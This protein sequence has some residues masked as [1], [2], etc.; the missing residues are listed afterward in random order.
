MPSPRPS[1][2]LFTLLVLLPSLLPTLA[3]VS[4]LDQIRSANNLDAALFDFNVPNTTENSDVATDWILDHWTL[5]AGR[6]A[7]GSGDV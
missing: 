7:F 3:Q 1:S 5:N 6:F 2:L 4:T